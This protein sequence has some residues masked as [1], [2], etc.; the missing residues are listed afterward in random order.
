M[1]NQYKIEG[2]GR[3]W[4]VVEILRE[5]QDYRL[6]LKNYIFD[7]L[8]L[9]LQC[10]AEEAEKY[11]T[12]CINLFELFDSD[13]EFFWSNSLIRRMKQK[14]DRSLQASNA[15]QARWGKSKRNA[16]AI[17]TQCGSNANK[18]KESKVNKDLNNNHDHA[19]DEKT[20]KVEPEKETAMPPEPPSTIKSFEQEMGRPLSPLEYD[21][22][23]QWEKDMPPPLV[24]EALKR[25]VLMGKRNFKYINSILNEWRL[26]NI[27]TMIQVQEYDENFKARRGG[28]NNSRGDPPVRKNTPLER[29]EEWAK[30]DPTRSQETG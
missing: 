11:I 18:V 23:I 28:G 27:M 21:Q 14:E 12:D 1:I 13:G 30:N 20:A 25:A 16:D 10:A 8:A 17:Q 2:Y 19:A 3:F 26:N 29:L 22:I 5:Q 9:R 15:A 4:I 24:E 6:P 7:A